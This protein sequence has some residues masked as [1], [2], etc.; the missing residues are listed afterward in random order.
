MCVNIYA[1][2]LAT[3]RDYCNGSDSR[4]INSRTDG[5]SACLQIGRR[6]P[7]ITTTSINS[8]EFAYIIIY[9]ETAKPVGRSVGLS[10]GLP[11][12]C[13]HVSGSWKINFDPSSAV[14]AKT[15]APYNCCTLIF[16][17]H[18]ELAG[19]SYTRDEIII[20]SFQSARKPFHHHPRK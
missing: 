17:Y 2:R 13:Q 11:L 4:V 19:I 8:C 20:I 5:D 12:A 15:I 6:L 1:I 14:Q 18:N 10:V 7:V 9:G 16:I 3:K